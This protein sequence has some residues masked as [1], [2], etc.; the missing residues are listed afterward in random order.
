MS[1]YPSDVKIL[2]LKGAKGDGVDELRTEMSSLDNEI[3]VERQRIDNLAHLSDGSTTGDAELAD[4][5]VGFNGKRYAD[6]GSAVRGQVSDLNRNLTRYNAFNYLAYPDMS[7][8]TESGLTY[9]CA[10]GEFHVSGTASA[11]WF[12]NLYFNDYLFPTGVEKGKTYKVIANFAGTDSSSLYLRIVERRSNGTSGAVLL[13]TNQT[14]EHTFRI[15]PTSTATGCYIRLTVASGRTV[16]ATFSGI[17]LGVKSNLELTEDVEYHSKSIR[18]MMPYNCRN[19]VDIDDRTATE[20]GVSWNVEDGKFT[21][22]GTAT[23]PSSVNIYYNES[24]LPEWFEYDHEYLIQ[25]K[26]S[27]SNTEHLLFQIGTYDSGGSLAWAVSTNGSTTLKIAHDSGV[28]GMIVRVYVGTGFS[29]NGSITPSILNTKTNEQLTEEL[30]NTQKRLFPRKVA[31][32]GDSV[33]WGRN[34]DSTSRVSHTLPST[35]A[36]MLGVQCDNYGVSGQGFLPSE[37]SPE[38]AYD[39]I[40]SVDLTAYDTIIICYGVNDGWSPIGTWDSTDE[41]TCLGQFNKIVNYVYQHNVSVRFIVVAP[42]NGRNVGTFPKYWYG[43]VPS[44]VY[45]RGLLSDALKQSCEYYNIPY[46]EQKNSPINGFSIQTIIGA[47]GV[48]PSANGYE[49]LGEWLAGEI[50]RLI[51]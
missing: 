38:T 49:R 2:M 8:K 36:Q 42:W 30:N 1:T 34:G 50:G 10:N 14:G 17:L 23:S 3:A 33:V 22:S 4:I 28:V 47:D 15:L 46:I 32:F 16:N 25:N 18:A 45:S 43:T 5:R 41:S 20:N 31:F 11:N 29:V 35:I 51:G 37:T 19:Y 24:S 40:S 44:S 39:N 48:H 13:E 26:I 6:A 27:G 7:T 9:S 21:A 12:E